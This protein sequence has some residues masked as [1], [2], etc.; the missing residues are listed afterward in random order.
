MPVFPLKSVTFLS[1]QKLRDDRTYSIWNTTV[2]ARTELKL[3]TEGFPRLVLYC[4]GSPHRVIAYHNV[5]DFV[6]LDEAGYGIPREE[7][8]PAS[9]QVTVPKKTK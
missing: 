6:P 8:I 7:V 4:E 5:A 3:I 1:P 9:K 2:A